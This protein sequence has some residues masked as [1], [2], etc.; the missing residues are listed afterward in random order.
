M[1]SRMS[2][3]NKRNL[4]CRTSGIGGW[5]LKPWCLKLKFGLIPYRHRAGTAGE[6]LTIGT[7]GY[8]LNA[9]CMP[10]LYDQLWLLC[11]KGQAESE[12]EKR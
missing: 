9:G 1:V 4:A 8:R 2:P 3:G 7:K 10:L 6:C 5:S 11:R 12:E